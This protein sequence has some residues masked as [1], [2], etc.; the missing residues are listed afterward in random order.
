MTMPLKDKAFLAA[1][2]VALLGVVA[3][4][5]MARKRSGRLAGPKQ[6][7]RSVAEILR[8]SEP[9]NAEYKKLQD[10]WRETIWRTDFAPGEFER[11]KKAYEARTDAIDDQLIALEHERVRAK[12]T[13]TLRGADEPTLEEVSRALTE[14]NKHKPRPIN[15]LYG[16]RGPTPEQLIDWTER[17]RA[18]NRER[19]RLSKLHK[20]LLARS[21]AVYHARTFVRLRWPLPVPGAPLVDDDLVVVDQATK[22][23]QEPRLLL[24][25]AD[26]SPGQW[27]VSADDIVA[28]EA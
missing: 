11:L 23:G 8:I 9:L 10:A 18:W 5:G 20:T 16:T 3:A 7:T 19:V 2:G 4:V 24:R 27:W 28:K 12:R 22:R 14:L 26:K 1:G 13:K 6:K 17:S 15:K 25:R 21:N